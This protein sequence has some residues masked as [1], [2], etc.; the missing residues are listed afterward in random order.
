MIYEIPEFNKYLVI[1][2]RKYTETHYDIINII[3]H[4][5]VIDVHHV[6]IMCLTS[7]FYNF[8]VS[9]YY[10]IFAINHELALLF[11]RK[12]EE[13]ISKCLRVWYNAI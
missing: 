11:E 8:S 12:T 3:I 5:N 9:R 10:H 2:G 1:F 7:A 6:F 13:N 4:V